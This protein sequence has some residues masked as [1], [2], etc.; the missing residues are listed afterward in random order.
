MPKVWPSVPPKPLPPAPPVPAAE[1]ERRRAGVRAQMSKAGID[2]IVLSDQKNVAYLTDYRSLSWSYH[3][4]PVFAAIS[5]DDMVVFGSLA[6]ARTVEVRARSFSSRYYDGYLPEAV[7]AISAWISERV[8]GPRRT[9]L[10]YGQDFYG[11]GSLELVEALSELSHDGKP[12]SASQILWSVRVIKSRFEAELK[13][14]AFEIVNS[15]FDTA[16]ASARLGMPEYELCQMVQAQIFLNGAETADPI[17]MLFSKG[18]FSY[19]RPASDR[20]LEAGHYI[21]TDFRATYGGYPADRNRIARAG[22]PEA[23]EVDVYGRVRALTVDLA[24]AVRP[25]MSCADLYARFERM[26]I[27]ADLGPLYS[28]VSR[29]GHGGGL[30]VTEP[31]SISRVDATEIRPGMILHL[32]PK[33]EREGAVFQF[34]EVILVTDTG[35]EFLSALSPETIPTVC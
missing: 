20:R 9:A 30:D 5:A 33:L 17:A 22:E 13:R 1:L 27:D 8:S 3:A 11:R 21:W 24:G 15:A 14:I 31:P 7:A 10:D 34:E 2:V 18:D 4:R 26:W 28:R 12:V 35:C 29:I 6:E 32:E 25:G 16:L 19:G 23:W